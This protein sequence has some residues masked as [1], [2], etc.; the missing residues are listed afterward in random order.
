VADQRLFQSSQHS[1]PLLEQCRQ[2]AAAGAKGPSADQRAETVRDL[3]LHGCLADIAL[4]QAEVWRHGEIVQ[5]G[6]EGV[7]VPG[8]TIEQIAGR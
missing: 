7:L 4:G 8:E 1:H 5:E 2:I 6:Q 3:L